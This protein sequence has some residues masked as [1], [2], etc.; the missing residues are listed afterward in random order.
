MESSTSKACGTRWAGLANQRGQAMV[1]AGITISLFVI[2]TMG[3]IEFGRAWMVGN[4]ITQAAREGGR[5][6]AVVPPGNRTAGIINAATQTTIATQVKNQISNVLDSTTANAFTVNVTQQANVGGT[7]VNEVQVQVTG[8]VPY[9]FNLPFVGTSF[10]VDRRVTFRD[11][12][13]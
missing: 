3:I 12:V 1:E 9:I 2:L 13:R 4:M 8:T 11:E 5:V 10:N 6:A 7:G